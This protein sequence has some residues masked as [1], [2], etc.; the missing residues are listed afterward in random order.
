MLSR[1]E[2]ELLRRETLE[3]DKLVREAEHRRI[4]REGTTFYQHAQSRANDEAGGRF[5]AVNA[6]TVVGAEPAVKYP[7]ASPSWQI[8]LPDEQPLAFDNPA[9]ESSA[10]S[11]AEATAPAGA[12][13]AADKLLSASA[14]PDDAG[15]SFSHELGDSAAVP[16]PAVQSVRGERDAGSPSTIKDDGNG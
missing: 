4:Q 14:Q 1:Q 13:A 5:A 2:E 7:A 3:N 10:L 6:A 12:T 8:Q 16:D 15:A 11:S 9:L